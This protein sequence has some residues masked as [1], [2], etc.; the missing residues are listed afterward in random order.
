MKFVDN[1]MKKVI[2]F[3]PTCSGK[4]ALADK[5]ATELNAVI[6]NCDSMQ[7]YSEIPIIT[8]QPDNLSSDHKLFAFLKGDENYSVASWRD[9]VEQLVEAVE[10][11]GRNIVIVGGTGLYLKSILTGFKDLP[12][13]TL[14]QRNEIEALLKAKGV[15]FLYDEIIKRDPDYANIVKSNDVQ[16]VRRIYG[17]LFMSNIS[18]AKYKELPNIT[19][20]KSAEFLKIFINPDREILYHNINQR[21]DEMMIN[22]GRAE[23]ENFLSKNYPATGNVFKA[24]GLSEV[25]DILN[26]KLSENEGYELMKKNTRNYAKRQITFFSNQISFDIMIKSATE[27]DFELLK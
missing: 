14:E 18:Y 24:I 15:N 23:V 4:S 2:I 8:A 27:F 5:V 26:N 10:K 9:D 11:Q 1:I 16:R 6:I 20:F 3:G 25:Q 7:L 13:N 21:V 17:L 12:T 19:K 22:G